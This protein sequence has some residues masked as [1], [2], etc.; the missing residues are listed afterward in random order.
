MVTEYILSPHYEFF[1]DKAHRDAGYD[2]RSFHIHKKYEIYYEL[3]GTRRYY[4]NDA[5]YLINAGNFVLIGPDEVHKTGSVDNSAHTRYVINFNREYLLSLAQAM[6][7]VDLFECFERGVH[8]LSVPIKQQN[9]IESLLGRLWSDREDA[10]GHGKAMRKLLLC[11]LLLHLTR[12]TKEA[13]EKETS[14]GRISHATI[15]KI[16]SYISTNYNSSLSLSAIAQQFYISPFYLSHLFKKTTN[17]S[18]VEY[19]N[20]VRMMAGKN[21]LETTDLSV[22]QVADETGFSNPAHFRRVFKESTGLS[23]QQ[24]R[25]YYHRDGI[26]AREGI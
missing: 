20:S 8:V 7:Q 23:P 6:P 13:A 11:E 26:R 9:I 25:K 2:M 3:E 19:I 10:S 15:E 1:I 14:Q 12:Y 24:Y 18:I 21:L 16:Q 22:A 17:L 4:I 5:A